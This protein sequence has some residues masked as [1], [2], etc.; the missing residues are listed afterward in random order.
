[1][2]AFI[3][4]WKIDFYGPADKPEELE[5]HIAQQ[6][7]APYFPVE[8]ETWLADIQ[9]HTPQEQQFTVGPLNIE[10]FPMFHPGITYGYRIEVNDKIIVYAPDNELRFIHQS[11]DDR[12]DEFDEDE[13]QLLEEMREE[14]H[15]RGIEFM[16]DVDVLIHDSQYSPEDYLKKRGWGHSCYLDTV[17]SAIDARVKELILF[18]HDPSYDDDFLDDMQKQ[19]A[20]AVTERHSEMVCRLAIEGEKIDLD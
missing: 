3:P 10:S 6:M 8:T 1:M 16:A 15:W 19:A 4:G 12:K 13:R 2:L 9:Y 20:Q 11:I 14:Q 17:N 18:S 5:Y 7:K